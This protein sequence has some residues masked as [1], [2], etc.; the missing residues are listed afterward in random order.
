MIVGSNG[1]IEFTL[2]GVSNYATS[3]EEVVK[4]KIKFLLETNSGE[5]YGNPDFGTNLIHFC[6]IPFS[7]E[8]KISLQMVIK[9]ALNTYLPYVIVNNI[10]DVSTE[11]EGKLGFVLEYT[12][13]DGFEDYVQIDITA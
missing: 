11:Y 6:H 8:V 1:L 4:K 10:R 2:A 7:A 5:V 3:P 12:L 9:L 13:A